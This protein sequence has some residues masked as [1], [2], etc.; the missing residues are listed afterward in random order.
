MEAYVK[1]GN[2]LQLAVKNIILSKR[3]FLK[4]SRCIKELSEQ[5][6]LLQQKVNDLE[7]NNKELRALSLLVKQNQS[8]KKEMSELEGKL[9]KKNRV[10]VLNEILACDTVVS[11]EV[12][13]STENTTSSSD[14]NS[15]EVV[16]NEILACDTVVSSEVATSSENSTSSSDVNS[17]E[18]EEDVEMC[19]LS[20]TKRKR[21]D[22]NKNCTPSITKK[23][24]QQRNKS[25]S[26][27]GGAVEGETVVSAPRRSSRVQKKN[28]SN[29]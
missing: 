10:H 23:K 15:T 29:K 28:N 6:E 19:P 14:V 8:L 27:S 18:D 9:R 4:Q 20:P 26:D 24:I 12:T 16:L 2:D 25:Q 22:Q 7:M 5:N 21:K 3:A 11:S 13:T 17:T 1:V